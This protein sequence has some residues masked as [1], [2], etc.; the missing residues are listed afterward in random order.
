MIIQKFLVL[1]ECFILIVI[2]FLKLAYNITINP[3]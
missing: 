3:V 2:H 1:D